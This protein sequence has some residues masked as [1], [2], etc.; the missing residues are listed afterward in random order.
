MQKIKRFFYYILLNVLVSGVT[1]LLVL[2]YWEKKHPIEAPVP[3][4]VL[5]PS[6]TASPALSAT[7]APVVQDTPTLAIDLDLN[8]E[9]TIAT[10]DMI[11]YQVQ[12]GD[13]LGTIAIAYGVTVAD[14]LAVNEIADPDTLYVGIILN[15]PT[16]PVEIPSVTI[17]PSA[18]PTQVAVVTASP[19]PTPG[20]SVTPTPTIIGD[21][22]RMVVVAVNGAGDLA[23]ERVVLARAG[24]GELSLA[25]W[26]LEDTDNHVYSFP[27]LVLYP[28]GTVNVYTKSGQDTVV[29]LYWGLQVSVWES[30]EK[31]TLFDSSGME[32]VS[33][34]VP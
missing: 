27:G 13:T 5:L 24:S 32:H 22:P 18:T 20:P 8:P 12:A 16:G 21:E 9:S 33:F 28:G 17:P 11:T 34:L 4:A 23:V 26:R 10:I 30:G 29:N 25:G 6:A 1:T 31:V 15:I 2:N 14:I 19:Q 7:I 3:L